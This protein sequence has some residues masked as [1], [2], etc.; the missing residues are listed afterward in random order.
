MLALWVFRCGPRRAPVPFFV[1]L[2]GSIVFAPA[3]FRGALELRVVVFWV[4]A[5]RSRVCFFVSPF[6]LDVFVSGRFRAVLETCTDLAPLPPAFWLFGFDVFE[7]GN[8]GGDTSMTV[9][10]IRSRCSA[11][12]DALSALS[13]SSA[14]SVNKAPSGCDVTPHPLAVPK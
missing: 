10:V 7:R 3:P 12:I 4:D 8:A 11:G 2:F 5:S 1:S 13:G 14:E 9:Q 6:G